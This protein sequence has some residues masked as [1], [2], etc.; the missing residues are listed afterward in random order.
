M[1]KITPDPAALK[2]AFINLCDS[3]D[4]GNDQQRL[5]MFAALMPL[6]R[7]IADDIE[8]EELIKQDEV[9]KDA[10]KIAFMTNDT[11][12]QSMCVKMM[13]NRIKYL[14]ATP[15]TRSPMR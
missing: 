6:L 7:I 13:S 12:V 1:D 9:V 11:L 5:E 4:A 2:K 3:Y 14:K 8:R 10:A 15:S